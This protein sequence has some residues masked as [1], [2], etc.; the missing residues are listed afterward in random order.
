MKLRYSINDPLNLGLGRYVSMAQILSTDNEFT[1]D[2]YHLQPLQ[3]DPNISPDQEVTQ[4]GTLVGRLIFSPRHFKLL[5][6][7]MGEQLARYEA[8]HGVIPVPAVEE[9]KKVVVN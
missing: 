4:N 7:V 8:A 2:G 6:R 3:A 1:L 5:Y 9:P